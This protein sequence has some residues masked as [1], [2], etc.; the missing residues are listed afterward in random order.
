MISEEAKL[1]VKIG[2]HWLDSKLPDWEALIDLDE[3]QVQHA[4]RCV[5]GQVIA[6]IAD[7]LDLPHPN[8]PYWMSSPSS[9]WFYEN[10]DPILNCEVN[11]RGLR[12]PMD[13]AIERGFHVDEPDDDQPDSVDSYAELTEA[14]KELL[15]SRAM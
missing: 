11:R 9:D 13:L 15:A 10:S 7:E 14:W 4:C 1:A 3:L 6:G 2:A 8:Q 5:L 12:M